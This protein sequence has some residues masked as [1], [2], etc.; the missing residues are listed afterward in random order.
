MR[1]ARHAAFAA[2]ALALPS[3]ADAPT[4]V[5]TVRVAARNDHGQIGC[6]LFN[7]EKGFPGDNGAA[8]QTLWCPLSQ[9][10][11][12]CVFAPAPPGIYAV[13]CFHD[14]NGNNKMDTNMFGIPKEGSVASNDAKGF[15]GPP[16]FQDA[17]FTLPA[18]PTE[19]RLK[20]NY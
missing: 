20:I 2:I 1:S 3:A 16:K 11:A 12:T 8:V 6:L 19:L 5:L 14:E 10:Q 4:A 7:S 17:K 9:L 18:G 15:M 13:A